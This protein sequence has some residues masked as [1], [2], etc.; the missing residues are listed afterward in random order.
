MRPLLSAVMHTQSQTQESLTPLTEMNEQSHRKQCA[1]HGH[2]A[3]C[4]VKKHLPQSRDSQLIAQSS[5]YID[6]DNDDNLDAVYSCPPERIQQQPRQSCN[7]WDPESS[8]PE[9]ALE[10]ARE[11]NNPDSSPDE[12]AIDTV[13]ED[14]NFELSRS[15]T[16]TR[17]QQASKPQVCLSLMLI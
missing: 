9:S 15:T 4:T 1:A 12:G 13:G 8:P 2:S 6:S 3:S 11:N 14:D 16:R 5:Q 10:S 7:L 17:N